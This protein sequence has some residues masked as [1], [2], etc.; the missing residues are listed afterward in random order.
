MDLRKYSKAFVPLLVGVGF[1]L[2]SYF[3]V[4]SEMS[5]ENAVYAVL[6]AI[7]VYAVPNKK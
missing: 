3:G 4:T 1:Y 2:L 5:V 7:G 6:A